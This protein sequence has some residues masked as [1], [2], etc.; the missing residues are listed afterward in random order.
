MRKSFW[1]I[2]SIITAAAAILFLSIGIIRA[3]VD[4]LVLSAPAE[5]PNGGCA[6]GQRLN[7]QVT[8]TVSPNTSISPNTQVCIFTPE[9]GQSGVGSS[10]WASSA[11]I[12][13]SDSG[14]LSGVN[15]L[16]GETSSI[17]TNNTEPGDDFLV[18]AYTAHTGSTSDTLEFVFN[19]N[20][21]TDIE[22]VVRVKVFQT[23]AG[24]QWEE[25]SN[26]SKTI[27]IAPSAVTSY[28]GQSAEDCES[29]SPCFINS[30]D[31]EAEGLGTG[32]RDAVMAADTGSEIIILNDYVIKASTVLIDKDLT[33]RGNED[34]MITYIGSDCSQPMISFISGGVLSDL[35]IN[36]GNCASP[37][38]NLI[39][40][41]SPA[42]VAIE[43]NTLNNGLQAIH[44]KPNAGQT[45]VA[46]NQITNNLDYAVIRDSGPGG[47]VSI[48]GNNITDNRTGYQVSCSS[49]GNADHNYWGEGVLATTS[50][51]NC[52]VS[53]GK[54]LGAPILLSTGTAGVEAIRKQVTGT[55]TYAFNDKVS[56]RHTVGS[57]FNL[58]IVN[59][60]QGDATNSPFFDANVE[61]IEP[62]SNF[63][64]VFLENGSAA[65]NLVLSLKYDLN[66]SCTNT[67]ETSAYCLGSDMANYPLWW[68]DPQNNVTDGWDTTGQNPA[69]SGAAGASGQQTTCDT[70]NNMISVNIDN[71]GRP[72]ISTDM[73]FIPFAAGL[74]IPEGIQLSQFT[75]TFNGSENNLRW[76]T[77]SEN[78]V[79]GFHILRSD[80]QAG[81]YVRVTQLINAIGDT[82]IGGVYNYP[83]PDIEFVKTYY[84]KIEV[85]NNEGESIATH[86]P[87]SVLTAT[88]TPTRTLTRTPPPT[89]TQYPT[90]TSTPYIYRSP[91]SYYQPRT[92]TP[93]DYP[94]Q[95]RTYGP[96]GSST[97]HLTNTQTGTLA[98]GGSTTPIATSP[99]LVDEDDTAATAAYPVSDDEADQSGTATPIA[100]SDA[101]STQP[102]EE[103]DQSNS[104]F[105]TGENDGTIPGLGSIHWPFLG[106]GIFVGVIL[107]VLASFILAKIRF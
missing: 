65:S 14:I 1:I 24:N 50:A 4:E 93:Q 66:A 25:V 86:G 96:A 95:V 51:L 49:N 10:P 47:E 107:V 21:S 9:D 53:Y 74:P 42:N 69:G 55:T 82:Y 7:F 29:N 72:G 102:D 68:Y 87:V 20:P 98:L 45:T 70:T 103:N 79:K 71:T 58:I 35:T 106:I 19:I 85:I 75:A 91:T 63:Y 8:F 56:V 57:D 5:C 33:I 64:D 59:H 92:S 38:R 48:F 31:D 30:G 89:Y 97:P 37:S 77:S 27:E 34:A 32:L 46:F 100:I 40:I 22:G 3:A 90:R 17:C 44:I 81:P 99:Y 78:N 62:C 2:I 54:R 104:P 15:Y 12:W 39:E 61:Q 84:Y 105:P 60:G 13:I 88:A 67:I 76:I 16:T 83:D 52:T 36:D 23:D 26:F 73:F 41:D 18:G 43:H 101:D 28:V 11:N 80:S 94:T 6:A